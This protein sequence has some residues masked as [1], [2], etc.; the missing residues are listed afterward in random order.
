MCVCMCVCMRVYVHACV[1]ACHKGRIESLRLST[2]ECACVNVFVCHTHER[3]IWW[4]KSWVVCMYKPSYR[5]A[6]MHKRKRIGTHI[7]CNTYYS[8]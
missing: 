3:T 5:H 1:C 7:E 4:I 6:Y 8:N 2:C